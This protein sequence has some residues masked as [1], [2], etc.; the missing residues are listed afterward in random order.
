MLRVLDVG[1][2]PSVDEPQSL[3]QLDAIKGMLGESDMLYTVNND[4]RTMI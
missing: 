3:A 4:E 2:M 1:G